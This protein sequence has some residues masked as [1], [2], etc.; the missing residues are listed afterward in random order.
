MTAPDDHALA[1]TFLTREPLLDRQQ[2]L[3]GYE[4]A[5][6]SPDL[7]HAD[8]IAKTF[9]ELGLGRALSGCRAFLQA[10]SSVLMNPVIESLPADLVVLQLSPAAIALPEVAARCQTLKALGYSFCLD[11][12]TR[13]TLPDQAALALAAYLKFDLAQTPPE[14]LQAL[15]SE[16]RALRCP[17]IAKGIAS[18]EHM[19]LCSLLGVELFQGYFFAQ[20]K[21][22]DGRTLEPSVQAI[23]RLIGQLSGDAEIDA[24]ETTMRGEPA[25]IINLLRLT[26]SVGVGARARITSVRHAITVLGRRQLMRWLQLLLFRNNG[27]GDMG[28]NALM[29]YAALRARFMEL[30]ALRLFPGQARLSDPAFMTGLISVLPAALGLS[31]REILAQLSL[32]DQ[33]QLALLHHDGELGSLLALLDAYDANDRA[34]ASARLEAF[35]GTQVGVLGEILVEALTWV[36]SLKVE[37]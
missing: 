5:L 9:G 32:D 21:A 14:D 17:V 23:F 26:N 30:L 8:V 15:T 1:T 24:L 6:D 12:L 20:P 18:H 11:Q 27:R 28:S 37:Q 7:T 16:L 29:Q 19:E 2:L 25:L 36:Q 34:A 3:A 13:A 33:V 35:P 22:T 4:I 31:M 10:D